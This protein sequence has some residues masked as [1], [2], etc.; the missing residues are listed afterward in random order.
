LWT[1]ALSTAVWFGRFLRLVRLIDR[2][3]RRGVRRSGWLR[4][5]KVFDRKADVPCD[6][7]KKCRS[8]IATLMKRYG[9]PAT[10]DMTKLSVRASLPNFRESQLREKRHDL[11]RFEDRRF[12]HGLRHF[13]GLRPDEHT[14]ESGVA[15]F[16]KHF[17]HFLEIRPQL[18]QRLAL[19]MRPWEARHPS[20]VETCVG[21]P[22]DDGREVLH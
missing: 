13:D 6:L 4:R 21:I 20:N 10:V 22:L 14:L 19:T 8:N 1:F 15:F 18:I 11:A 12:P 17:D 2:R 3:L 5:Q 9:R 16:K 7:S